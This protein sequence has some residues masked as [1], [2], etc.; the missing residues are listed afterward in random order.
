MIVSA[1]QRLAARLASR[2][3]GFT[4]LEVLVVV[5]IIVILA[6]GAGIYIFGFLDDSKVRAAQSQ[7]ELFEKASK[8]FY[9]SHGRVPNG[10][11]ELVAP[12]P[13]VG[14]PLVDGG[15]AALVDPWGID[16]YYLDN[17]GQVDQYGSPQFIVYCHENGN[18]NKPI[19][20]AS[21]TKAM[22]LAN[23]GGR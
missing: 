12:D 22:Q 17:S 9:T 8:S 4:L 2:R 14:K 15:Q 19:Y 1:R 21:R 20:S 16:N 23:S 3:R 6:G 11:I 7:C 13:S 10:L 5:A 18:Q